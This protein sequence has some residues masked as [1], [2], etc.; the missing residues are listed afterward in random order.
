[1]ILIF[2][3]RVL[4]CTYRYHKVTEKVTTTLKGCTDIITIIH[5]MGNDMRYCNLPSGDCNA[6]GNVVIGS[7]WN[8]LLNPTSYPRCL[9]VTLFLSLS[10]SV[11]FLVSL[12][13]FLL[14]YMSLSLSLPF[15]FFLFLC[16]S[17][18]KSLSSPYLTTFWGLFQQPILYLCCLLFL[19]PVCS[20]NPS[21]CPSPSPPLPKSSLA[22]CVNWFE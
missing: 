11:H 7:F 6:D 2:A 12:F 18:F 13:L 14:L 10:L 17:F 8:V 9:P 22:L 3:E 16:F 4:S 15:S 5:A 19:S 21:L 1:M 20:P